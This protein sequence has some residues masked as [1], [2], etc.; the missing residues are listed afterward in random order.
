[1][2]QLGR[3]SWA[4]SIQAAASPVGLLVLGCAWGM[5]LGKTGNCWS[6]GCFCQNLNLL[7]SRAHMGHLEAQDKTPVYGGSWD[8]SLFKTGNFLFIFLTFLSVG[9]ARV[10]PECWNDLAWTVWA[11]GALFCWPFGQDR[12]RYLF[13]P[14]LLGDLTVFLQEWW[15]LSA[16]DPFLLLQPWLA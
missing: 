9:K 16:V 7:K 10:D 2:V 3:W 11:L 14:L 8:F 1:M 12:V 6:T 5:S 4:A 13:I 15:L